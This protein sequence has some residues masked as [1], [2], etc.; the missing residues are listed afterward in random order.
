[1][2]TLRNLSLATYTK[3]NGSEPTLNVMELPRSAGAIRQI[4]CFLGHNF[5]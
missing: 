1:M 4:S 3:R 2:A 5:S